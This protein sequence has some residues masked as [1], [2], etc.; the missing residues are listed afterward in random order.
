M[1]S[2]MILKSVKWRFTNSLRDHGLLFLEVLS[3]LKSSLIFYVTCRG[4]SDV[5]CLMSDVWGPLTCQR[6]IHWGQ[7]RSWRGPPSVWTVSWQGSSS[8]SSRHQ[9][10]TSH[11][12]NIS[13]NVEN[14]EDAKNSR[15]S[16]ILIL[17][18]HQE[19]IS[20]F[21]SNFLTIL[22]VEKYIKFVK[23]KFLLYGNFIRYWQLH[24]ATTSALLTL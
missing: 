15:N 14:V 8:G 17:I 10:N 20:F 4:P 18:H 12:R 21:T 9:K 16:S 11:S 24:I 22:K 7:G 13:S 3:Q 2:W 23:K 5:W 1:T 6:S 19:I